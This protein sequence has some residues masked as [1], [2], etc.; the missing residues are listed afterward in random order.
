MKKI[1]LIFL[2]SS[3]AISVLIFG[4]G[5][6]NTVKGGVIGAVGGGVVGGVVGH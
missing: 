4:C 3:L 2:L 6:S 1:K 5:A